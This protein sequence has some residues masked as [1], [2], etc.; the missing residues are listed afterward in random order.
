M[1]I[2]SI[3]TL[4]GLILVVVGVLSLLGIAGGVTAGIVEIVVGLVLIAF[5]S[6]RLRV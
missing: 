6:G 1:N 3:L 4:L 5:G 2:N